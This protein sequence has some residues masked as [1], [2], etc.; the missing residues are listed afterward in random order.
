MCRHE[1][2]CSFDSVDSKLSGEVQKIAAVG[3][4]LATGKQLLPSREVA[5]EQDCKNDNHGPHGV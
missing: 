1:C 2:G 3:E 5:E 4:G